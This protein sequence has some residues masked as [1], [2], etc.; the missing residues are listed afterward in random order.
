[1][2]HARPFKVVRNGGKAM[3]GPLRRLPVRIIVY[4]VRPPPAYAGSPPHF[5][6]PWLHD[7]L[8]QH[9]PARDASNPRPSSSAPLKL[10]TK[11]QAALL[12]V[13]TLCILLTGWQSFNYSRDAIEAITFA[14]LTGI[15][16]T[17]KQQIESYVNQIRNQIVTLAEDRTTIEA[18]GKFITGAVRAFPK[19]SRA[20]PGRRQQPDGY[21]DAR[22]RYHPVFWNYAL[23]FRY[24]DILLADAE[25]G[26]VVYSA[27]GH[28]DVGSSVREPRSNIARAFAEASLGTEGGS[29]HLVD[30]A[31]C[32]AADSLPAAFIASPVYDGRRRVAVLLFELSIRDINGV[33]TS[34]ARWEE[35]GLG[36]TGETYIVGD[37]FMMRNDSRFFVEDSSLYLRRLRRLGTDEPTLARI[38]SRSTTVL[39]QQAKT[40]ATVDALLGNTDTR[41]IDDYRGMP[42]LSSYTPLNVAGV[43]W[44]ILAEIDAHEA[45]AP[46]AALRERLIVAGLALLLLAS[47]VGFA[48]SRRIS[49]PLVAL[50]AA[51]ER[52]GRG[53]PYIR[54]PDSSP[55]E[56]GLLARTFNRMAEGMSEN[57]ERL[58]REITERS[59]AEEELRRSREELR[60]LSTHLQSVREEERQGLAREIHDELGQAISS[61]KLELALMREELDQTPAEA[62]RRIASMSEVCDTTIRAVRRI[63]TQ[64]R[65]RLLDDL[66]L[67]A[68]M[69]WQVEEFQHRTDIRCSLRITPEEVTLDPA[70]STAI[71][72]ILQETLTNIA[73]HSGATAV[74]VQL[75]LEKA[76][77]TLDVVDNGRGIS[78][79]QIHDSRSFGVL[80]IRERAHY[81]GG[82]VTIKGQPAQGTLVSVFLPGDFT[83]EHA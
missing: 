77:V 15:R 65:P 41:L 66:G 60:N 71:F 18:A 73:R 38:R 58:Q 1:M 81:W 83:Q 49:H 26:E 39:I 59:R 27:A 45:L 24:G 48:L 2:F 5:D 57:T 64:L 6:N 62:A 78:E 61:L 25:T 33:M 43:R 75:R 31:P 54:V 82:T 63:I 29:S 13:A 36:K 16:E 14:R 42:V 67:T 34:G 7:V 68:A 23:R 17:K 80:G 53:D 69:E 56:M 40:E 50:T 35:E 10:K 76:G 4:S 28:R 3:R 47:A 9:S 79:E 30:F 46:V 19:G 72:R 32:P 20:T 11:L 55:D 12:L 21:A 74:S 37:D 51:T 52:F 44:V 70:R 8:Q 22:A